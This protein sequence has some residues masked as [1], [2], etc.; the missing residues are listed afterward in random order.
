MRLGVTFSL[1]LFLWVFAPVGR[2]QAD[3]P[4][5]TVK[6]GLFPAGSFEVVSRE[7]VGK[8][9]KKSG[10]YRAAEIKVP[11]K[12]L[13]TGMSLRDT[14][15]R[16]KLLESQHPYIIAKDVMA[17]DGK[18]TAEIAIAGVSQKI[19]FTY[20]DLRP[21]LAEASFNLKLPDFKISGISYKG[22]GVEDEILLIVTVP[23]D[24]E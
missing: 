9:V 7:V 18:G 14:H 20:K 19:S 11:V 22:V 16:E 13:E 15:L 10:Q 23:Y 4:S 6:V 3:G 2:S 21:G 1:S 17:K 5:V 12:S 24:G 8:G